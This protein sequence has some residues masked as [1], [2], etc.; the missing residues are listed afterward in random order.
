MTRLVSIDA[1][2]S[3]Q[4]AG[5]HRWLEISLH[6]AALE[7]WCL[8]VAALRFDLVPR[9]T[10]RG[11]DLALML[12]KREQPRGVRAVARIDGGRIDLYVSPTELDYWLTFSLASVRDGHA[13]VDHIDVEMNGG[14][15]FESLVLK[16]ERSAP[17]VRPDEARRRLNLA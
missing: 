16:F 11:A 4:K 3:L 12:Q 14:T 5:E 17:A 9:L 10:I 1:P 8:S 7:E 15:P 2:L 6:Q 13:A